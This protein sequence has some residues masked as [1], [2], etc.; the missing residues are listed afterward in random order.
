MA[1]DA[2]S[3]L[4]GAWPKAERPPHV[5]PELV[6]DTQV[7]YQPV[8][9]MDPFVATRHMHEDLPPVFYSVDVFSGTTN[10]T[11]VVTHHADIRDVYQ[12]DEL[13]SNRETAS[14]QKLL[15][16]TWRMIPLTIDPPE[17][18]KYRVMLNPWF[19][20]R[21]INELIDGF[22]DKGECDGA[23]DFARIYPVRVFMGLMGFPEDKF[24]DFLRWEY[25]LLHS[26]GDVEKVKWGIGS[27]V[28]YLREFVEEVRRK[29]A[30]NLSSHI[31]H[32]QIEGRPITDD[33]II[34][35]I[36]FLWIGGLDTVAATT[37]LML[38]RLA[39]DQ[40]LQAKLRADPSVISEAVEEFLRMNP[41]VNSPRLSKKDHEI[42][43]VKIREGDWVTCFN[44]AGNFD[45]EE[46]PD[47]RAFKLDRPS[48]R[49]FSLAGGPH[50]CLGSHLARRE[51]R[52]ALGEFLR[53]VP[54]FEFKPGA[55]RTA[56]PGL[57]AMPRLPLV[58]GR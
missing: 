54:Q 4:A 14:F 55:D 3:A 12:T 24:D 26:Y 21:A 39:F 9:D 16:E 31:I 35:T 42:H 29:P 17:H 18:G 5:P 30:D 57:I 43:G 41:L 47:P 33:E 50:R 53:R 10:G 27:A 8:T 22:I 32:S 28:K 13:Y 48:N 20:P 45:A 2:R 56:M 7:Y 52:L 36:T 23:Y 46:F 51:L 40:D 1:D 34:G 44:S 58:W 37:T 49:H 6:H 15:G 38:R 19:S 25:A 11:W